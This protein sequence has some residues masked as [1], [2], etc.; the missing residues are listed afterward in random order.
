M[1]SVYFMLRQ[2]IALI[3]NGSLVILLALTV[4][5]VSTGRW[6]LAASWHWRR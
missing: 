6:P 4:P 5:K 3:L 1:K 2:A